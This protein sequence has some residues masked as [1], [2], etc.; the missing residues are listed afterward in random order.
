MFAESEIAFEYICIRYELGSELV[1]IYK[2]L[3]GRLHARWITLSMFIL[4]K[5]NMAKNCA[6]KVPENDTHF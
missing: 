3:I 5:I 4:L 6:Y 1:E 2:D